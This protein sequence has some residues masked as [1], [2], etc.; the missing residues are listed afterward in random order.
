MRSIIIRDNKHIHN[1]LENHFR[2]LN[3]DFRLAFHSARADC[4]IS[5]FVSNNSPAMLMLCMVPKDNTLLKCH[6]QGLSCSLA[7]EVVYQFL[8]SL[9]ITQAKSLTKVSHDQT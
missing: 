7:E 5:L 1:E 3:M 8:N 4:K 9:R 6:I 2:D